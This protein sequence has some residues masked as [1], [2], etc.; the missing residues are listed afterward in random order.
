[1]KER[2]RWREIRGNLALVASVASVALVGKTWHQTTI[3]TRE[4][5]NLHHRVY[6][7][8]GRHVIVLANGD[9]IPPPAL[10]GDEDLPQDSAGPSSTGLLQRITALEDTLAHVKR[11]VD[12]LLAQ[13]DHH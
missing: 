6:Y 10:P 5:V 8:D 12:S 13:P 7:I 3:I 1:M 2:N 11:G 9:T 4:V